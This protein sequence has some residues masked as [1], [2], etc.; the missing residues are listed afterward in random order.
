[1]QYQLAFWEP[2]VFENIFTESSEHRTMIQRDEII[3]SRP[4]GHSLSPLIIF[5]YPVC[6]LV[7]RLF[8]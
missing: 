7:Y 8:G 1:M 6:A 3:W 2:V 5:R 4:W